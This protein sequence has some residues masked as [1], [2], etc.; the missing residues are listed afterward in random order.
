MASPVVAAKAPIKTAVE[1]GKDY[2][3]CACGKS[4][5]QPFCDGSHKGS[6]FTPVKYTPTT[7]GDVW[8]CACK[9]SG[10]SPMCDGTHKTV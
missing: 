4:T 9:H 5:K 8:F 1:A 7:S 6:E 2:W 10:K 3:W